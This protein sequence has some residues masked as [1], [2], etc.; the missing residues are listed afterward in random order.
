[1]SL[2]ED[3]QSRGHWRVVIRPSTF[4]DPRVP[5]IVTLKPI[6][7]KIAVRLRGWDYPHVDDRTPVHID[8]DW[9]G[10]EFSWQDYLEIWRFYQSGQLIHIAGMMEDWHERVGLPDVR[11][12][13]ERV[14]A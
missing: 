10:Q 11:W 8:L 2:L 6:L 13:A 7:E 4:V 5:D 12:P 1:M 3:I 9:I 14:L